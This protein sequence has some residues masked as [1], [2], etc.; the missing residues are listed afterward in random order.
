MFF[1]I[2]WA[3]LF[4]FFV[5]SLI[6]QFDLLFFFTILL[7]VASVASLVWSRYCLRAVTYR[8]VLKDDR[9]FAGEDTE[10]SIEVTN[11][12]PLPLAW[13]LVRDQFPEEIDLITG[14]LDAA[15]GQGTSVRILTNLLSMRWYE[16]V[17]RSYRIRSGQRGVYSFGPVSLTSGDIFGFGRQSAHLE[18]TDPLL[19]YPRVVPLDR[20]SLPFEMPAGEHRA[21][22]RTIEDP[23]RMATVREYVPGD[24]MRHIH[25]KNTAR[26][27][28]LQTK[29]FDPSAQQTI[30]IFVDLQT[31]ENPY[32]LVPEYLELIIAAAASVSVHALQHR[33]SVGLWANGGPRQSKGHWT[34]IPPG[35]SPAQETQILG[36]L[37]VLDGFRLLPFHQLLC[38]AMPSLPYGSTVLPI[39]AHVT[40]VL[41]SS[42]LALQDVGHP[43][44][45]LTVG[46]EEPTVERSVF[47]SIHLGGRDAWHRLE[48]LELA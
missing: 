37:A 4:I 36:A 45:L 39:T 29:V 44:L 46:D 15:Q 47:A 12:K 40:D 26:L 38:R 24:S 35:R 28:L 19:V 10:L 43:I 2:W 22:R 17:R 31:V 34:S 3:L 33:Q 16:R 30:A 21:T 41:W 13:L 11:A 18:D 14:A 7:S 1:R 20:L 25:W 8:R 42:L 9:I 6:V 23:L 48:A 32:G 27:G 5:S